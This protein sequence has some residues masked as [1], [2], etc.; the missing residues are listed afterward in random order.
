MTKY[1]KNYLN[2]FSKPFILDLKANDL[3]IKNYDSKAELYYKTKKIEKKNKKRHADNA[4]M[5]KSGEEAVSFGNSKDNSKIINLF[6]TTLKENIEKTCLTTNLEIK[7]ED[8]SNFGEFLKD[9]S[10]TNILNALDVKIF[11]KDRIIN[12]IIRNQTNNNFSTNEKTKNEEF[13]SFKLKTLVNDNLESIVKPSN[14]MFKPSM[15]YIEKNLD[16]NEFN[17]VSPQKRIIL[18]KLKYKDLEKSPLSVKKSVKFKEFNEINLKKSENFTK[19]G[20]LENSLKKSINE[21]PYKKSCL[22][23]SKYE[24]SVEEKSRNVSKNVVNLKSIKT[25]FTI[26]KKENENLKI[27]NKKK[28]EINPNLNFLL[29]TTSKSA[30]KMVETIELK[31]NLITQKIYKLNPLKHSKSRYVS[32]KKCKINPI[33]VSKSQGLF[34]LRTFNAKN[35][36]NV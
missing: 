28:S 9:K 29:K 35:S 24:K 17:S 34:N 18:T 33:I 26:Y 22:Q 2:F 7:E 10:I 13:I 27:E 5:I 19:F 11:V 36:K 30:S 16:K 8:S 14:S 6:N 20:S 23:N 15:R 4:L 25:T 21:F 3:I 31:P 1:Y 12:R 32:D